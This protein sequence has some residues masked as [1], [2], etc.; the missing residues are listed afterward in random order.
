LLFLYFFLHWM[1]ICF[2]IY[3]AIGLYYIPISEVAYMKCPRCGSDMEMDTHRKYALPM[4]YNCG[5]MEGRDM[6]AAMTDRTNFQHI[7]TLNMNEMAAYLAKK[8][9]SDE[10]EVLAWLCETCD[11]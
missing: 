7:R 2:N 10:G 9:G 11:K 8:L 3:P 1:I 6:G 4:C 5:Y